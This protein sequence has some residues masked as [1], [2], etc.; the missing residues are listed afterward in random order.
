MFSV[1]GLLMNTFHQPATDKYDESFRIQILG[2]QITQGGEIRKELLTLSVPAQVYDSF[3]A[4]LGQPVTLPVG[5][6]A[7]GNRVQA[8]LPKNVNAALLRSKLKP[9]G[10]ASVAASG[11]ATLAT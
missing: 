7:S 8:F 4:S 9:S 1:T 10:A 3:K 2:D 5:L 6:F 11:G